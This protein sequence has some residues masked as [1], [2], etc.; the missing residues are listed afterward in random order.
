MSSLEHAISLCATAY[1]GRLTKSGSPAILHPLRLMMDMQTNDE[2]IVAMLHDLC[3]DCPE[4]TV[5][6]LA[7]EGFSVE[8]M[9]G[10]DAV[11]MRD[12]E[13][14]AG[15]I[16]RVAANELARRVKLA[17][18]IAVRDAIP[19]PPRTDYEKDRLDLCDREIPLL[20]RAEVAPQ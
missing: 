3:Y 4:W 2:R 10:I 14:R 19:R 1:A 20:Q 18:L 7:A 16:A 6:R 15:F 11:T 9:D 8:V 12:G 17:E 13:P 5:E